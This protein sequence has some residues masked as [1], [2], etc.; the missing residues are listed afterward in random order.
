MR[1]DKQPLEVQRW[2]LMHDAPEAYVVDVPRPLKRFM[3]EYKIAESRI[4]GVIAQRFNLPLV[5]PQIVHDYDLRIC[6]DERAHLMKP[7]VAEWGDMGQPLGLVPFCFK[8]ADA[9]AHFLREYRF[10]FDT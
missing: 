2:A 10:L 7:C 9:K 1:R 5:I 3:K 6:N 4:E 8:P